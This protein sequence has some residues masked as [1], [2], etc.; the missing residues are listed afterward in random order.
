MA[1]KPIPHPSI[2]DE[3]EKLGARDGVQRWRSH[4]GKRLYEWD[5]LH[6]EVE[7]YDRRG[8]HL[9][10][11]DPHTGDLIKTARKGRRIDV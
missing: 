10:A 8:N 1:G 6:G 9:G 2:L 4:G 11:L 5:A 7:V 3:F